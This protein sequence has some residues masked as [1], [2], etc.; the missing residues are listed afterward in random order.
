MSAPLPSRGEY[1]RVLAAG[2][3]SE[4]LVVTALGNASYLWASTRD[5]PENF[6]LEDA[7]GLALPLALGLALAQRARKVVVVEGDGGLLMHLGALVTVGAVAPKNLT[8]LIIQN[9]VHAASGGQRLTR[10]DLDLAKL[11]HSLK[12]E[13]ARNVRTAEVFRSAL[14]EALAGDGP[15][16]LALA[17]EPDIEVSVPPFT[18]DPVVVKRRFMDAI[19]APRYV[20]TMFGGGRLE[21]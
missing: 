10:E 6:Y 14:A 9:G 5:A 19:G 3:P 8:V 2:L 1:Y 7:M 17:T 20:P 16:L 13:R 4:A 11:A 15:S 21:E 18:F 12:L